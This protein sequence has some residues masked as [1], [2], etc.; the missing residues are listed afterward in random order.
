MID[1]T[2]EQMARVRDLCAEYGVVK[3]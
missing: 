2:D 3:L 1:I